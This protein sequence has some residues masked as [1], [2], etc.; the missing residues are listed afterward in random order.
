MS[1]DLRVYVDMLS[2]PCR[3]VVLFCQL[4]GIPFEVCSIELL[5][6][7]YLGNEYKEITPFQEVPAIVHKEYWLN[8]SAAIVD[9]L[10]SA[11]NIDN[12]WYPKDIQIKGQIQAFLHWHHQGIRHHQ[13]KFL[14]PMV[15]SPLFEGTPLPSAQEQVLQRL[16]VDEVL[17]TF[18]QIISKTGYAAFTPYPTIADIFAF[19]ELSMLKLVNINQEDHPGISNWYSAINAVP[20]VYEAHQKMRDTA[21][22]LKNNLY[23]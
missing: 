11:F 12:H 23:N 22:W 3:S 7:E 21:L 10:A 15:F 14:I 18:Q 8:E 4:S 13:G 16:H 19:S 17:N 6:E 9:Y 5:K 2:E 20:G 1:A